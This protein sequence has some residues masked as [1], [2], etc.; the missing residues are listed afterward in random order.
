MKNVLINFSEPS[1]QK[2]IF[3]TSLNTDPKELK[4]RRL[5]EAKKSHHSRSYLSGH[6]H[7][8]LQTKKKIEQVDVKD[9]KFLNYDDF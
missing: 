8:Y 5:R 4:M 9:C 7:D 2:I 3:L 6:G 1:T